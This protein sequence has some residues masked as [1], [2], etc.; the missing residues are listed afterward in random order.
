MCIH[1]CIHSCASIAVYI[2]LPGIHSCIYDIILILP[3]IH[4][5]VS[6]AV[7][8]I[9]PGI[10]SCIYDITLILPGIHSCASIVVYMTLPGIHS[11]YYMKYYLYKDLTWI[12]EE[13]QV[14]VNEFS[15]S[16]SSRLRL[17]MIS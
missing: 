5:C 11:C 14:G 16:E 9:L 17:L 12:T 4:S 13:L 6:I 8:M 3:G 7:Y 2:I 15:S 10:H 1:N